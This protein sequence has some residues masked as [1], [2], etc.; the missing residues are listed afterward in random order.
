[1]LLLN[2]LQP[3]MPNGPLTP[4]LEGLLMA[5]EAPVNHG[6]GESKFLERDRGGRTQSVFPRRKETGIYQVRG[7]SFKVRRCG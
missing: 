6:A 1:M 5:G 3:S 4:A 2:E 7:P